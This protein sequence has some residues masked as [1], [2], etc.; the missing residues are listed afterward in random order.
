MVSGAGLAWEVD[1]SEQCRVEVSEMCSQVPNNG[2]GDRGVRQVDS[3]VT[4]TVTASL[5]PTK[6]FKVYAKRR[7]FMREYMRAYRRGKKR[8]QEMQA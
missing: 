4:V 6:A 2:E 8:K 1:W 3:T 7:D 5:S